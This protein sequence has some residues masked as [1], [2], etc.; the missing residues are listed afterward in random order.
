MVFLVKTKLKSQVPDNINEDD[1]NVYTDTQ[2]EDPIKP[3]E[4]YEDTAE[5]TYDDVSAPKDGENFVWN[6]LLIFKN[7]SRNVRLLKW[8][9]KFIFE[10]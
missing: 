2:V 5:Q 1:D 4:I 9:N 8:Y 10:Q 7:T 6:K 3:E